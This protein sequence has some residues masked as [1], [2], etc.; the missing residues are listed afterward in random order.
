MGC[1]S[2]LTHGVL[3]IGSTGVLLPNMLAKIVNEEG[4]G[5]F[6]IYLS[7]RCKVY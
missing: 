6:S 2:Y 3:N 5:T 7:E 4:K 1:F